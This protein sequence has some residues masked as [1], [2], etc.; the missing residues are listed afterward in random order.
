MWCILFW[1]A[2]YTCLLWSVL[3]QPFISMFLCI[4][5]IC[6]V[7][8]LV[9]THFILWKFPEQNII[10]MAYDTYVTLNYAIFKVSFIQII[11]QLL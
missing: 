11:N 3:E 8:D 2:P 5:C 7:C 4:I 10:L 6:R 1:L 9:Y